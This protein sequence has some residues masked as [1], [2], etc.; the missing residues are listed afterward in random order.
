MKKL[1]R[2]YNRLKKFARVMEGNLGQEVIGNFLEEVDEEALVKLQVSPENRKKWER[3]KAEEKLSIL[4]PYLESCLKS[5]AEEKFHEKLRLAEAMAVTIAREARHSSR[6]IELSHAGLQQF[7]QLHPAAY[8]GL[9]NGQGAFFFPLP[10]FH[11]VLTSL[12]QAKVVWDTRENFLKIYTVEPRSRFV[13]T[14]LSQDPILAQEKGSFL[15]KL[16]PPSRAVSLTDMLYK[17]VESF[18]SP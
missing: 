1:L 9:E 8:F 10:K 17:T 7:S 15:I 4:A 6:G 11:Q 2:E 18:L 5:K 16:S 3:A 12:D 13:F 14:L